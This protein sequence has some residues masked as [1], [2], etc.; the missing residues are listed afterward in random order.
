MKRIPKVQEKIIEEAEP[1]LKEKH[2][3]DKNV[4]S[5]LQ[6]IGDMPL[7]SQNKPANK[8]PYDTESEIKIVKSFKSS[9]S[10]NPKIDQTDDA[11]TTFIGSGPIDMELDVSGSDL[12]S[13]PRNDLASLTVFE[14]PDS[15]TEESKSV[16]KEHSADNIRC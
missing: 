8:S 14:T 12:Y 10:I 1:T 6:S 4:D 11:N 3:D 13:M 16:T 5:E 7:E 2:D 9:W 15:D